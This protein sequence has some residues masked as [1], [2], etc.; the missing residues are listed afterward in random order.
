MEMWM[1]ALIT[2]LI[3]ALGGALHIIVPPIDM[4]KKMWV[5]RIL[6]GLVVGAIIY[7]GG[8]DPSKIAIPSFSIVIWVGTVVGSGYAAIDILKQFIDK[9][10]PKPTPPEAEKVEEKKEELKEEKKE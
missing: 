7:L 10:A 6:G 5:H 4:D 2:A 3:G 8:P 9:Y 1:V